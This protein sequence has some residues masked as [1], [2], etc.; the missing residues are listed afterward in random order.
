MHRE[1]F[2]DP[3]G[4]QQKDHDRAE[5]AAAGQGAG[6][7]EPPEYRENVK[8]DCGESPGQRRLIR[9]GTRNHGNDRQQTPRSQ[10]VGRRAGDRKHPHA[11][12]HHLAVRQNSRQNRKRGDPHGRAQEQHEWQSRD[13]IAQ[14]RI[15]APGESAAEQERR[16]NTRLAR[17]QCRL[18][19]PSQGVQADFEPPRN[20]NNTSP[21]WLRAYKGP[22]LPAG[23]RPCIVS[24][25]ILPSSE[26]PSR[27]PAAI[28]PI[29]SG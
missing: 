9:L 18:C 6:L 20:I 13:A 8:D 12:V 5:T 7:Q 3:H 22:M 11:R 17:Q 4:E 1:C 14:V 21:S 26:G 28:S 29:T 24:G 15:E 27:I 16:Q 23:K 10:I 19:G 2:S 25:E